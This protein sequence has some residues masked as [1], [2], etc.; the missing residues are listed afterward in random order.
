MTA[1]CVWFVDGVAGLECLA[2]VDEFTTIKP[3]IPAFYLG[4][5]LCKIS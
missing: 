1:C 3:D 5:I 2:Q 4:K